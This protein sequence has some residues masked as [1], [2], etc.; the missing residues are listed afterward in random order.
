[1]CFLSGNVKLIPNTFKSSLQ[2]VKK[3]ANVS[4]RLPGNGG[5][6]EYLQFYKCTNYKDTFQKRNPV[7]QQWT[8]LSVLMLIL[9]PLS[10]PDRRKFRRIAQ[11]GARVTLPRGVQTQFDSLSETIWR[12]IPE[13]TGRDGLARSR[14][15]VTHRRRHPQGSV[16]EKRAEY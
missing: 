3:L 6:T 7:S 13:Q 5:K 12:S 4:W 11:S 2:T 14:V 1:M 8:D 16:W 10:R 9:R 15:I